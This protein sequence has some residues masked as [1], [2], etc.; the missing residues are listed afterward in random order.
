[1]GFCWHGTRGGQPCRAER[2]HQRTISD[3]T[4][5]DLSLYNLHSKVGV[6]ALTLI[7]A[8]GQTGG[9]EEEGCANPLFVKWVEELEM[10]R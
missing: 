9:E 10:R 7:D 3:Q 5:L 4:S 8:N 1:M 2:T 6:A